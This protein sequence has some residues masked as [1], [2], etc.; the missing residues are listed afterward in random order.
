LHVLVI[1][2]SGRSARIELHLP[3]T[4]P[5]TVERLLAPAARSRSGVTLD[6]QH[7]GPNGRWTGT[8]QTETITRNRGGYELTMPRLSAALVAVRT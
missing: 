6:G 4:G 5:A 8:P 7:L 3:A 2:K 1:D